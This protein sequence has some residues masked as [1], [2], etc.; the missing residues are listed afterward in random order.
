M[1]L[2]D[3]F[4]LRTLGET[5]TTSFRVIRETQV[6]SKIKAWHHN[7]TI[8][9]LLKGRS[10][11]LFFFFD[12]I[13]LF[14]LNVGPFTDEIWEEG[15]PVFTDSAVYPSGDYNVSTDD[16]FSELV[17]SLS[18]QGSYAG[19]IHSIGDAFRNFKNLRSLDLSRNLITSLKVSSIFYDQSVQLNLFFGWEEINKRYQPGEYSIFLINV[20]KLNYSL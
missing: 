20:S 7:Q 9:L 4:V 15:R 17:E 13:F 14:A 10:D 12:L 3:L 1:R 6:F 5:F 19:K 18:L 16:L 2:L 8:L 11:L